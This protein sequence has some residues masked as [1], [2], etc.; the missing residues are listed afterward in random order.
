MN[1]PIL[2]GELYE[3]LSRSSGERINENCSCLVFKIYRYVKFRMKADLGNFVPN[4]SKVDALMLYM[5]TKI[6]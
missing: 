1:R 5:A 6:P 2:H 4:A 3:L